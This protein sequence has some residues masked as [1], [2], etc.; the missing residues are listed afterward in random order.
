LDHY[1]NGQFTEAKELALS[2][3]RQFPKYPFGWKALGALLGQLGKFPEALKANEK[4]VKLSPQDPETHNNL[5]IA[6][7]ELGKLKEAK[8]S[9]SKAITLKPDFFQVYNNLGNTFKN[10]GKYED[11]QISFKKA[12]DLNP[13]F[14]EA[15][16]N[17][18]N[19]LNELGKLNEAQTRYQKAIALKPDYAEAYNNLGNTLKDLAKNKDAQISFERA[20]TLRPDFTEAYNNLGNIQKE[21][22]KFKDAQINYQKAIDL[23]PNFAEAHN[24]LGNILNELGKLNEAQTSYQ[25]AITLKPDYAEAYN[26]LGVTLKEL[27][28]LNEAESSHKY[29]IKLNPDF[30]DAYWNL[31]GI[32]KNIL[33]AEKWIDKCLE[34]NKNYLV[35]KLTK[36]AL[37]FYQGECDL[38]ENLMQSKFKHH[39]YI[40]SFSWVFNLPNQPELHFN[41]WHFFDAIIKK[42]EVSKP[43]YEFGVWRA[44]SFKYLIK[45]FKK[46]YGFDTFEGLPEDW[47]VGDAIEKAGAYSSDGIVPKIKGGE[48]IVGKFEDTLPTFFSENRPIAS[49]INF[50]ADLYSSTICALNNSKSIMDRDT[51]L[52]FD[53]F[54]I[55]DSWEQDEFKALNEFCLLNNFQ[56]EVIAVSF[57]T[58]QVAIKLIGI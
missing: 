34:V 26:S 5:G 54:I 1:Q 36:A 20:I 42:S 46:G 25:K 35:A 44:S 9:F 41:K 19:I 53:E 22:G 56:Y 32:Q 12:I 45:T 58:K 55:N 30:A 52:I 37:R 43:F 38:Y 14:A 29:A 16:N 33:I 2:I 39:S 7:K 17:L 3:T 4:A 24:N 13:N 57:F 23:N 28:N 6:L 18:G 31:Y 27:G 51:I 49:L 47:D 10:L 21:F 11:A 40:R 8:T 50:D 15:H 48:F